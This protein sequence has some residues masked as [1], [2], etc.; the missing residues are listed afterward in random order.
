MGKALRNLESRRLI[1]VSPK[2]VSYLTK[3]E[4]LWFEVEKCDIYIS[5][6]V[7]WCLVPRTLT[8]GKKKTTITSYTARE[9]GQIQIVMQACPHLLLKDQKRASDWVMKL[10][11]VSAPS[12]HEPAVLK[13]LEIWPFKADFVW[14]QKLVPVRCQQ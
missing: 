8:W 13:D 4:I 9:Y 14:I 6:C 11:L 2:V 3:A 5:I 12:T 1:W 10:S 7:I